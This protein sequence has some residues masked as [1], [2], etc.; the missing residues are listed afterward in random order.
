MGIRLKPNESEGIKMNDFVIYFLIGISFITIFSLLIMFFVFK[1]RFD[2]IEQ[3][4]NQDIVDALSRRMQEIDDSSR[5][6]FERLSGSLGELSKATEQMLE[7]GKT[8]NSL[9][10]LL[11][12]PKLRGGMGETLLEELLA[13]ILPAEFYRFQYSF[14]SGETVDAIVNLGE[15]IVPVDAKFPLE[16]FRRLISI[17]DE[18]QQKS[19]RKVFIRQIKA[20]VD[21]IAMKY[22]LPDEGTYDFA[23]MY[24]PA[25]NVYYEAIIKNE[26]G[27]GLFP[28][29]M[30]K[31]V[32]PV[33]PNSFYAYLQV[34]VRGLRGLKIEEKAKEIMVQLSRLHGD[35][36]RFRK[37]FETLG[38]HI[39]NA[40]N[41][42]DDAFRRLNSFED[43]LIEIG[44]IHEEP[45]LPNE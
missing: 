31:R 6:S 3:K 13:Q 28:Y 14:R 27:E 21:M 29:A 5:K 30:Q 33:S 39:T 40:R 37:E 44:N 34:I 25:E 16:S 43:K 36:E 24:I 32:I 1:S 4:S 18:K 9:E 23:L 8:I 7:V 22:I 38:S 41:K 20:H 2:R 26:E 11:K 35:E 17:E 10:D 19:E 42:Y 45:K 15:G 12:P